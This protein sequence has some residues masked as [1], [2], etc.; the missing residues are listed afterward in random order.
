MRLIQST[1][2]VPQFSS[3]N[4]NFDVSSVNVSGSSYSDLAT[5]E[6]TMLAKEWLDKVETKCNAVV[7]SYTDLYHHV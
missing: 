6:E 1:S 5:L 2:I 3:E 4:I 7:D